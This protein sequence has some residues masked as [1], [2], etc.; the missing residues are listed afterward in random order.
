MGMFHFDLIAA[1][2]GDL[3]KV[4]VLC[5]MGIL[6]IFL[7]SPLFGKRHTVF[8]RYALW[9]GLALRLILPFDLSI[10]GRA[11][12]IPLLSGPESQRE[13][14]VS[15]GGEENL[16][17]P[18]ERLEDTV[19]EEPVLGEEEHSPISDTSIEPEPVKPGKD[20]SGF[21]EKSDRDLIFAPKEST[22][23]SAELL[24]SFLSAGAVLL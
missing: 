15:A 6:L 2:F 12:F 17:I 3:L 21:T 1:F 18:L 23:R 9:I 11:V 4:S 19:K 22:G 20:S 7:I 5:G 13:T 8:W 14:D 24:R 16:R 10:P